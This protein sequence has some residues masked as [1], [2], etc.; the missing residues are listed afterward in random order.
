MALKYKSQFVRYEHHGK[1]VAVRED[2]MGKHRE[3]CLCWQGCK[4]FHPDNREENCVIA[5]RTFDN[6]TD[7]NIVTPIWECPKFEN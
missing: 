2:L 3:Y 4:H 6:C 5:T 1:Q 7:H